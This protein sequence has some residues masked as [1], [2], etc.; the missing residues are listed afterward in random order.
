MI[1]WDMFVSGRWRFALVILAMVVMAGVAISLLKPFNRRMDRTLR[2]IHE[3]F[4]DVPRIE[5]RDLAAWLADTNRTPPQLLDVRTEEEFEVSHLAGAVRS[6][7]KERTHQ[8]RA[9]LDTN[10]PT[11]LYCSVGYRSSQ[12]AE[13]LRRTGYTNVWS[14]EGSIFAWA[15]EDRPLVGPG[16]KPTL[17]VHPYSES[18]IRL[19]KPEHRYPLPKF[20]SYVK[21]YAPINPWKAANAFALLVIFLVWE[22]FAPFF[23]WFRRGSGERTLHGL[24]NVTLGLLNTVVIAIL[25]VR[26]WLSAANW[27]AEH[28]FGLLNWAGI[29]GWRRFL[30]V[31]L[32]FDCWTYF[33]HRI[34]HRL[35]FLWWFHR[36]HHS[37]PSMDV[38]SASRFHIGEIVCSSLLRIPVILLL[39]VGF[40][41]LVVYETLMFAVVQF[42]HANIGLPRWLET[43]LGW[44]IVTPSM[45]RVHHSRVRSETDSNYSSC[46]SIWDR[47]FLTWNWSDDVRKIKY[48]LDGF[49]APEQHTLTG[50]LKIPLVGPTEPV[51][52]QAGETALPR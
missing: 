33:W 9:R 50:M 13:E 26:L 35:P 37:E 18:Y 49:D 12:T 6:D 21:E 7:P 4:P 48:G 1:A 25:F 10:R 44:V 52:P 31:I 28:Q 22:S 16:D 27:A 11:V 23:D 43:A 45:H 17:L 24:R 47:L 19:I 29:V 40:K 41:E 5:T 20:T 3:E 46:L 32:L 15:N 51:P 8:L 14:L 34:N 42:S 36:M 30:A 39:G 2:F 38:T